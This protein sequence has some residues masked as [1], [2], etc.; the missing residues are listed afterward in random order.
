MGAHVT[1]F[2]AIYSA[3]ILFTLPNEHIIAMCVC[4]N[5]AVCVNLGSHESLY[6]TISAHWRAN[7]TPFKALVT[8]LNAFAVSGTAVI[9]VAT[10][11]ASLVS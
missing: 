2:T 8:V 3:R 1:F 9:S 6:M 7:F 10:V 11:V 4:D 5:I